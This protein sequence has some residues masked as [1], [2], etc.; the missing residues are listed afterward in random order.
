MLIIDFD[1]TSLWNSFINGN[2]EA[3]SLFYK[4]NYTKLYSY[5]ICLN[6]DDETIR[7]IIQEI[8][9]KLYTNP[10]IIKDA[11]SIRSFLYVSIRNAAVNHIEYKKKYINYQQID[12]FEFPYH[13]ENTGLEDEE[14]SNM[15]KEK[16]DTILK[17]LTPRQ[18]EIIYL[19]FLQQMEYDEIAG[20][21][22]M[23]EQAARNL[24]HRAIEK[25]RKDNA[26]LMLLFLLLILRSGT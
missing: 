19:R 2:E 23:T 21:M 22:N 8:F 7:D 25:A 15:V 11:S 18:K 6:L 16:I 26:N 12:N 1:E 5:G 17:S 24:V 14:E 13:I 20:I 10:R 4:Q 3:F 9:V